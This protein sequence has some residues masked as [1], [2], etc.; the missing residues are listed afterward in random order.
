MLVELL[1]LH[2]LLPAEWIH[3]VVAASLVVEMAETQNDREA[4]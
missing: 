2:F 3:V 4:S 1:E